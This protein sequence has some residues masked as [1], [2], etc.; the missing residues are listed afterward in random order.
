[1][2]DQSDVRFP[3]MH[4]LAEIR[5]RIGDEQVLDLYRT[6]QAFRLSEF[7]RRSEG[8]KAPNGGTRGRVFFATVRG[9]APL[10]V[11]LEGLL[12]NALHARGAEVSAFACDGILPRCDGYL[13]R[14]FTADRCRTCATNAQRY[15]QALGVEFHRLS[16]F[17]RAEDWTEGKRIAEGTPPTELDTV[18]YDGVAVG[19]YANYS[20]RFNAGQCQLDLE[21]ATLRLRRDFL[22]SGIVLLRAYERLLDHVRPDIVIMLNGLYMTFRLMWQL[23][24]RRGATVYTYERAFRRN[25]WVFAKDAAAATL[26]LDKAWGD[27]CDKPLTP[28]EAEELDGY[29]RSR[30]LGTIEDVFEFNTSPEERADVIFKELALDP[31]KPI[32]TLF[33]NSFTDTST[34]D[35]D[36]AFPSIYDWIYRSVDFFRVHPEY[37][38]VLRAH[39]AETILLDQPENL[40]QII[41]VRYPELPPNVRMVGPESSI[42]SYRL[43]DLSRVVLVYLSTIGVEAALK[44]KACLVAGMPMYRGL[45]FTLDVESPA[46]YE[47]LLRCLPE[48]EPLAPVQVDLARRFAYLY[49]FRKAVILPWFDELPGSWAYAEVSLSSLADLDPGVDS[50]LDL[51][52]EAILERRDIPLLG[53]DGQA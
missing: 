3:I 19:T 49:F 44:G 46:Q 16:R 31:E 1:M 29:I 38:L 50:R 21:E 28:C 26:P 43:C 48:I 6:D 18:E 51:L 30:E 33:P 35:M 45:G 14:N 11:A 41:R 24:A 20:V 52:C 8:Y 12:A 23:A 42:S 7:R 9:S 37:Q 13:L 39:P 47:S 4:A 27:V 5:A 2:A 40:A 22:T 10:V 25:G 34:M 15:M 17:V 53:I 36:G 32:A